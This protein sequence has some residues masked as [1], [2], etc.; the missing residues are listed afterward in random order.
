MHDPL[1]VAWEIKYPWKR[2]GLPGHFYRRAIV[3][4]WHK[5]P[6]TDGSDSSCDHRYS[7][8]KL[9]EYEKR[10]SRL[11]WDAEPIFDN[12]PHYPDSREHLWF[13]KLKQAR[14]DWQ[15][16]RGF[17]RIHWKLHFWHYRIQIHPLQKLWHWIFRRCCIC[18][19]RFAWGESAIGNW[20]G[21]KVWHQSC[22]HHNQPPHNHYE[23]QQ[24]ARSA[25]PA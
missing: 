14:W 21:N 7:R 15:E 16:R 10:L 9:N 4:I 12:R 2:E 17:F 19:K 11:I 3:T 1:T 5:D 18:G 24:S 23:R 22:D 8:R 6:C 25:D 20:E 13:Q